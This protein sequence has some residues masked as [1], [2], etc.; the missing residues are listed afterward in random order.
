MT[1]IGLIRLISVTLIACIVWRASAEAIAVDIALAATLVATWG[2]AEI[3]L[4]RYAVVTSGA[5][6]A[7]LIA[8]CSCALATGNAPGLFTPSVFDA[9]FFVTGLAAVA[10]LVSGPPAMAGPRIA[11][12]LFCGAAGAAWQAAALPVIATVIV[13]D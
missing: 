6:V 5:G 7:I 1:G 10:G 12:V 13:R 3:M 4:R 2:F 11:V 9:A 8:A